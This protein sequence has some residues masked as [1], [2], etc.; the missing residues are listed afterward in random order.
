MEAA[1]CGT[2]VVAV[3]EGGYRETVVDG[4]TGLL[5]DRDPEAFGAAMSRVLSGE[6]NLDPVT[7]RRTTEATR[8]WSRAV[9][10]YI[11]VVKRTAGS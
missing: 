2:P 9:E 7:I 10:R 4:V 11:D 1:A 3:C 8:T 5:T 6:A